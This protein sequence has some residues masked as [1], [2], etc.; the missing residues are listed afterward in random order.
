MRAMNARVLGRE[1]AFTIRAYATQQ[2]RLMQPGRKG[3]V[4]IRTFLHGR[5][6]AYATKTTEVGSP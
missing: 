1:D 2:L 3:T 5:Y 6:V 4:S